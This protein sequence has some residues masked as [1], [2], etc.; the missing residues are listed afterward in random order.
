MS[1]PTKFP[2]LAA[3]DIAIPP[4]QATPFE[5]IAYFRIDPKMRDFIQKC[6]DKHGVLG[7]QWD[8]SLN[9]GVILKEKEKAKEDKKP[10]TK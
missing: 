6:E 5:G 10:V 4:D 3:I 1:E 2:A 7:F 9:F 8:G